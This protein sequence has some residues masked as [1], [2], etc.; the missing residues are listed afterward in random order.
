MKWVK[1]KTGRFAKRPHYLPEEL[2]AKCEVA[3]D[4]F[5][6]ER[7]GS[8]QFP[9][10][11]DDLTILLEQNANTLDLYAEPSA[12]GEDVEGVTDF[13]STRKPDVRIN[14]RLTEDVRLENRLRTTLTHELGH[15]LLHGFMFDGTMRQGSLFDAVEKIVSNQCKR[16]NMLTTSE[17]DWMEWQAGF[18]CGAYLMPITAL[19]RA[20]QQ[21]VQKEGVHG[22]RIFLQTDTGTALID[23]VIKF[24]SVSR[25]AAKVR[26]LQ[27]G[28]LAETAEIKSLF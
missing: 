8:V 15:V 1:D 17:T 5:L 27:R 22:P 13:Y 11:T 4:A 23:E 6:K 7:H 12:L 25:D 10:S 26:L 16:S 14:K 18:A 2:D 24:F 20:V 28:F 21:F 3:I 19:T 9:M